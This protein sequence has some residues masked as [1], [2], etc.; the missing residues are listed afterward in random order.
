M[1]D[2]MVGML[3][4]EQ[5][6]DDH[7]QQYCNT[8]FDATDDKKKGLERAVSDTQTSIDNA[9]EAMASLKEEIATLKSSI[10]ELDK[11][12]AEATEQRKEENAEFKDLM[13]SNTAAKQLLNF[14]KNRLN[15][16]YNPKMYRPPA[17]RELSEDDRVYENM[18]GTITT[19]APGGIA[20]T[21]IGVFAQVSLHAHKAAPPPP[22]A[23]FGAYAHKGEQNQGVMAMIDLLIK[24]LDK[25]MTEAETSEKEGQADYESAMSDAATKRTADANSLTQKESTL[26]SVETDLETYADTKNSLTKELG[27]TLKYLASLHGECDWL[28]KYFDVRKDARASEVEALGKAKAVLSGAEYSLVQTGARGLLRGT[29]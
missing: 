16:F 21:G 24:D 6:D 10:A 20:G 19:A 1:I 7:K 18:G 5:Q 14:A 12:V 11:S 29:A 15:K 13:A 8:Q 28:L 17:K 4:V 26:A 3:K 25:E 9:N 23:T 22:P 27:A 2:N